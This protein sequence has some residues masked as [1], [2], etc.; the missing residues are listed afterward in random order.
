MKKLLTG[1]LLM[2][3]LISGC[4]KKQEPITA[5]NGVLIRVNTEGIGIIGLGVYGEE[6]HFDPEFPAQS[7]GAYVLPGDTAKI[8][9]RETEEG[10]HFVKWKKN[11]VDYS[12]DTLITVTV[13]EEVEYVAVFMMAGAYEGESVDNIEDAKTMGD[14]LGLPTYGTSTSPT[15]VIQAIELNGVVYRVIADLT[16]EQS[17]AIFALDMSDPEFDRKYNELVAPLEITRIENVSEIIPTQEQMDVIVGRTGEQLLNDGWTAWYYNAEE[18]V[19]GMYHTF[20]AYKVKFD[21]PL[22]N[23]DGEIED[24]IKDLTVVEVAYDGIGDVARQDV[25]SVG[26]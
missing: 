13:D 22:G 19:V 7:T 26:Y 20:F 1:I 3:V 17:D 21:K 10:W 9:A 5:E 16:Q 8:E 14:I 18:D 11:G 15:Q 25:E 12:T 2:L 6:P 23:F 24:Q 4:A